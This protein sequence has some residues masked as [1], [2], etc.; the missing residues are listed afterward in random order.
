MRHLSVFV[1]LTVAALGWT[2]VAQAEHL[3]LPDA[4]VEACSAAVDR[5]IEA[6]IQAGGGPKSVDVAPGNCDMFWFRGETIGNVL[7]GGPAACFWSILR[8]RPEHC[9]PRAP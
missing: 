6:G 8:D 2:A 4:T 7:S 9:P 3:T 1:V 5:Q